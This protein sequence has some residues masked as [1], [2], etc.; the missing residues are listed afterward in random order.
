MLLKTIQG[1]S[2]MYAYPM[3]I[4]MKKIGAVEDF[5]AFIRLSMRLKDNRNEEEYHLIIERLLG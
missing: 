4:F 3:E 5:N 1:I 2:D